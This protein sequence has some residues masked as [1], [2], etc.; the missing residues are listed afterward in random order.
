MS[1]LA[2]CSFAISIIHSDAKTSVVLFILLAASTFETLVPCF[3]GDNLRFESELLASSIGFCNWIDQS[4]EFK[5]NLLFFIAKAQQ[6][7]Q[8][9]AG[10]YI[11]CSM[12]TFIQF[13]KLANSIFVLFK[14]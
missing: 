8:L 6:P 7:L 12:T 3:F 13:Q 1:A 9:Q 4:K 11:P 14:N 5:K 2:Q 10:G